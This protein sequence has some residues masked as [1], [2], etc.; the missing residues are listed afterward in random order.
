MTRTRGIDMKAARLCVLEE[1]VDE[2]RLARIGRVYDRRR[3]VGH[4]DAEHAAVELPC[5]LARLD[6]CRRTLGEARIREA[7]PGDVR[8]EDP[9]PKS[10][11]PAMLV[12]LEHR[13]PARIDV[14]LL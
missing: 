6:G 8:R 10:A 1:I 14:Q 2:A 5:G 12:R 13:H 7:I 4:D 11:T 3:A 9:H